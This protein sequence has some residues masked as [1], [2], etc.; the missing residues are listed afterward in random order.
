MDYYNAGKLMQ[1]N[2]IYI[3]LTSFYFIKLRLIN[4]R[5]YFVR[6]YRFQWS[7]NFS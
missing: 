7:R 4:T 3:F 2:S 1:E 5:K 6:N